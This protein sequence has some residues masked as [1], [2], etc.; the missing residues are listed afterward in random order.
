MKVR[1]AVRPRFLVVVMRRLGDVPLATPLIHALRES[2]P[3]AVIDVLVFEGTEHV[4]DGSPDIENVITLP[5]NPPALRVIAMLPSLL[6][7]YDCTFSTQTGDR[8]TFRGFVAGRRRMGLVGSRAEGGWWKK[9]LLTD[10]RQY[11]V[12]PASRCR[13]DA[14]GRLYRYRG[15][16]A[17]GLPV[18][19]IGIARAGYPRRTLG[20]APSADV[21][22]QALDQGGLARFCRGSRRAAPR[23]RRHWQ[24]RFG[25][26]SLSGLDLAFR[27][28]VSP[29]P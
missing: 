8:P 18:E 22:I 6:R 23:S 12:R 27:I 2:V 15:Q 26:A 19:R 1:A 16:A 17:D 21:S 10:P 7:N 24:P 9:Y 28:G 14:R 3:G 25:G 5:P 13:I 11:R 29:P 4:L 20:S